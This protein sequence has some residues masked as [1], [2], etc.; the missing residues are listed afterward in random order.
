[1]RPMSTSL[2]AGAAL[3]AVVLSLALPRNSSAETVKLVPPPA[4]SGPSATTASETAV[5]AGGCFW[6]VQ[7][8]FQHVDGVTSAVSGYAGGTAEDASYPSVS[9]GT[10]GHAESVK[11][12]YDPRKVS[13]GRLLQIYF[14]VVADPTILNAQGPDSGRQYRTA[15][16]AMTP[17][18][19]EVAKGYIAQLQG[20]RV[21]ARPIVTEVTTGAAFYPA[22]AYHQ[23]YLTEHPHNPYIARNDIPK[24]EGLRQLFAGE[25]REAPVLTAASA[26]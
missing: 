5:L 12:T 25:Y 3:S 16:F 1:M 18:Q 21:F 17:R 22:E 2:L 6:G 8:V 11:V 9:S 19:A 23:N 4:D 13:F 20:A 24:V 14:S 26:D 7:G 15:I 10:T